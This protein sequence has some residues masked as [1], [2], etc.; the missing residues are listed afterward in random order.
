MGPTYERLEHQ[1]EMLDRRDSG[2]RRNGRR[3]TYGRGSPHLSH[4]PSEP[5]THATAFDVRCVPS[6]CVLDGIPSAQNKPLR[7]H[8]PPRSLA[9]RAS[10]AQHLP[11]RHH[12][13]FLPRVPAERT[14]PR[15]FVVCLRASGA[16]SR[17]LAFPQAP[18]A[19]QR[20]RPR[21]PGRASRPP[22]APQHVRRY[23]HGV[24]LMSALRTLQHFPRT[25]HRSIAHPS[26]TPSHQCTTSVSLS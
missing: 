3:R 26:S 22:A 25:Y 21:F 24:L 4:I 16:S 17:S 2:G 19:I 13:P 1:N 6:P 7:A 14:R 10:L 12:G 9:L 18:H 20:V 5:R 23:R 11:L 8:D 15:A